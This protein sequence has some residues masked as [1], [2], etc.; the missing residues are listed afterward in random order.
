MPDF[1]LSE[2]WNAKV[3]SDGKAL[4]VR[5]ELHLSIV[6][7][8]IARIDNSSVP[9]FEAFSLPS[10]YEREADHWSVFLFSFA[11]RAA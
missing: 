10:L 9:I 1:A 2:E 7:R 5:A 11:F 4:S 6:Y 8:A 3:A